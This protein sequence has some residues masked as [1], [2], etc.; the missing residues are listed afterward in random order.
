[1]LNVFVYADTEFKARRIT[2]EYGEGKISPEKRLKEKDKKR[3][4]NYEYYT[5]RVWG[6]CSNYDVLLNTG[7]IGIEK[8]VDILEELVKN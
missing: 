1:M 2:D 5:D 7:K 8:C 4:I 6:E 3:K